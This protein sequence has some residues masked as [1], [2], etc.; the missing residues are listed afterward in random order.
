[1]AKRWTIECL[2]CGKKERFADD[3]DIK[4]AHW[5]ILGWD[6]G[7]AEPVCTC[8]KCEYV[9]PKITKSK[10]PEGE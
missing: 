9:I 10:N 5:K 4:Q 6:V 3:K 1:M 8:D 2:M 7:S